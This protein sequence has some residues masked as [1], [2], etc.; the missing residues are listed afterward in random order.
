[1]TA[2]A[3]WEG[4][5]VRPQDGHHIAQLYQDDEFL[6]EALSHFVG[7]GLAQGD[8]VVVIATA[9]HWE[10]CVR[11]LKSQDMTLQ[12]AELRGQLA[13]LDAVDTLSRFMIEGMP[14]WKSFQDIVGAVINRTRRRYAKVRALT[15][16]IL[17][18]R[19]ECPAAMRL[20]ELW[21][22]LVKVQDLSLCCAYRIDNLGAASY[23]GHLQSVCEMHSHLIP[24]RDYDWLEK[25]VKQASNDVLGSSL[26]SLLH[27]LAAA[28]P[29]AI[30]MPAAQ[31]TLLWLK[32]H[33]PITASTVLSRLRAHHVGSVFEIS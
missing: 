24:Q 16:D 10:A 3:A 4:L 33:M 7:S 9:Q 31:A 1:M 15:V 2:T 18:Q 21:N 17:W 28:C 32:E 20:E 13:V 8:G 22:H 12:E 19:G 5:L 11:Q 23:D 27:S 29:P 6:I 30:H 26:A 25:N 14:D